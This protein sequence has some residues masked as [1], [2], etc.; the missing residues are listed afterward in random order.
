MVPPPHLL[1]GPPHILIYPTPPPSVCLENK[2]ANKR[3][4]DLN[5]QY[6]KGKFCFKYV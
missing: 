6:F 1:S 5:K 4:K 2:Q 3:E